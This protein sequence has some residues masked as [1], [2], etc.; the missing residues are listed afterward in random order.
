MEKKKY[1]RIK[2]RL[3]LSC[4]HFVLE[5]LP[6]NLRGLK[7]FLYLRKRVCSDCWRADQNRRKIWITAKLGLEKLRGSKGQFVSAMYLRGE[8]ALKLQEEGYKES[9]LVSFLNSEQSA[10][11]WIRNK[12]QLLIRFQEYVNCIDVEVGTL[13]K[14]RGVYL[15][16]YRLSMMIQYKM[17]V[18][19]SSIFY[20]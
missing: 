5:T 12:N 17:Y 9:Y 8:L 2:C 14:R 13:L 6:I 11:W 10:C 18:I 3:W 16:F 15:L 4:G 19:R 20:G 7:R 1:F